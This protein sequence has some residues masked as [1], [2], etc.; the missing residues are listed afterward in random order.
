MNRSLKKLNGSAGNIS[1]SPRMW[2]LEYYTFPSKVT[3]INFKS[4]YSIECEFSA[5]GDVFDVSRGVKM[6]KRSIYL[7]E[8]HT[9][10]R[11]LKRNATVYVKKRRRSYKRQRMGEQGEIWR[12]KN[13]VKNNGGS[14]R[15]HWERGKR[16]GKGRER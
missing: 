5:L 4:R 13:E 10:I 15:V 12:K 3:S 11:R 14:L 2:S 16:K 9:E 1:D 8:L 7:Q 6:S